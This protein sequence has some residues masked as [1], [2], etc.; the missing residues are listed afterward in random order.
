[1]VNAN[2]VRIK[3]QYE[4]AIKEAACSFDMAFNSPISVSR[5]RKVV[6]KQL[7]SRDSETG[8][9]EPSLR[10]RGTMQPP[11]LNAGDG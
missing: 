1:M 6:C 3:L 4:N 8:M 5:R 2:R 10:V 9:C 7:Q 11:W